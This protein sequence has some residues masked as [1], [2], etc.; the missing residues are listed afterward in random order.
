MQY[1][2]AV[3]KECKIMLDT[4]SEKKFEMEDKLGQ[5]YIKWQG[6]FLKVLEMAVKIAKSGKIKDTEIKI[7]AEKLI[8]TLEHYKN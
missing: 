7:T 5:D 4:M 6:T 1:D 8:R 3:M 2:P